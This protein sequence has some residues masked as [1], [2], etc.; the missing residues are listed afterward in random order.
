MGVGWVLELF[1]CSN[2]SKCYRRHS[3]LVWLLGTNWLVCD[4]LCSSLPGMVPEVQCAL[5]W[6][7]AK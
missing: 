6:T 4:G 1:K 7:R 2:V 3:L 5:H